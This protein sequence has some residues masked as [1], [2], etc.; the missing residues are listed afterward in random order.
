LTRRR[1][2]LFALAA[3][4]LLLAAGLWWSVRRAER[5]PDLA[6]FDAPL[7]AA[8]REQR[9]DPDLLRGVVAA[10]SGGD[11]SAKS[12]AGALGLTQLMPATAREQAERLKLAPPDD[13]ALLADPALNLRLGA[14][15]LRRMLDLFDADE[16]LALAAYNAGPGRVTGWRRQAP[17]ADGPAVLAQHGFRETRAYV[18]R[19]RSFRDRY[20]AR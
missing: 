9:L 1:T 19:V 6:R 11:E 16:V 8:A 15:Y 14:A 13:A 4:L 2:G 12:R 10:E 17:G 20:R 3:L 18:Q 7:T 5:L